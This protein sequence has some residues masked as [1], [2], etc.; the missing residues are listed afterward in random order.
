MWPEQSELKGVFPKEL[1]L[2]KN[3]NYSCQECYLTKEEYGG[4]AFNVETRYPFLDRKVVQ[5]FL[6]LKQELKNLHYKAPLREYLIRENFPFD[7][8]K[9]FGFNVTDKYV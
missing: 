9:K 7:E 3:F 8:G 5:E 6:W 4:G 2:W 1:K